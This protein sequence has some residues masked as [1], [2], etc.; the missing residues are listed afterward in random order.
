[1][2]PIRKKY[3]HFLPA[4]LTLFEPPLGIKNEVLDIEIVTN[5]LKK[6]EVPLL[7]S[8]FIDGTHKATDRDRMRE[9][10]ETEQLLN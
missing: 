4:L 9:V 3:L 6:L 2:I 5:L 8:D 10:V 1:M 7:Q